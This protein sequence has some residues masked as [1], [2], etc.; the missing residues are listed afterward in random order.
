MSKHPSLKM[1]EAIEI[2]GYFRDGKFVVSYDFTPDDNEFEVYDRVEVK[3]VTPYGDITCAL[4]ITNSTLPKDTV[5]LNP[6]KQ[7]ENGNFFAV[8]ISG[9]KDDIIAKS[10]LFTADNKVAEKNQ[11]EKEE[12]CTLTIENPRRV[13]FDEGENCEIKVEWNFD[14]NGKDIVPLQSDY[15]IVMPSNEVNVI[16]NVY[17]AH[18][19][20]MASAK[21][22]GKVSLRLG[23][24][25]RPGTELKAVYFDSAKG[26]LRGTSTSFTLTK[27][28]LPALDM[29][30]EEAVQ[31]M[32]SK[33]QQ[34][35][36]TASMQ[37]QMQE[38]LYK[39]EGGFDYNPLLTITPKK[40]Q[41]E[42][43]IE[44]NRLK[45]EVLESEVQAEVERAKQAE[46]PNTKIKMEK[47]VDNVLSDA[48]TE[49]KISEAIQDKA[50][51][52]FCGAGISISAPSSSPSW[53]DLMSNVLDLTFKAVPREHL[54]IARKLRTSDASR[55]PEEVM[56][57]YYFVLQKQLFSL[58]EILNEGEPNGNHRIIAKMAKE[59]KLRSIMTTNFDEFIERA[60]D[61]ERIPYKVICTSIEFQEYLD[62]GYKGF[63][64][65]KI[66]GTVSRPDTIVAVANHYKSGKGFGGVKST[67]T[68]FFVKN[69][70]TI[71]LGYS[72]ESGSK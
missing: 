48:V 24:Y 7:I 64:V 45:Y 14:G 29:K 57:T 37:Y 6:V 49:S 44:E 22:Q 30:D 46:D 38:H 31:E 58:F 3:E 15:I 4:A 10:A 27:D 71:F 42:M 18:V 66:H 63:V 56:E 34:Y 61:E 8:F 54:K 13:D 55:S 26:I 59:G 1:T 68:Q 40:D 21:K 20:A 23:G 39:I 17:H 51:F 70:P 60:L 33:S 47:M 36:S 12:T 32:K 28:N 9:A 35:N 62:N 25:Y 52:L 16:E 67:V 5:E 69:Y 65:L 43:M 19:L 72:G 41:W 53:W 11:D 50:A 2:S